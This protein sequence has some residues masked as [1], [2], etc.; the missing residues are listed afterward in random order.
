M[1]L[2]CVMVQFQ[3]ID[4][5]HGRNHLEIVLDDLNPRKV[6]HTH[7]HTH[8]HRHTCARTPHTQTHTGTQRTRQSITYHQLLSI[9]DDML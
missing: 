3:A 2:G 4:G 6:A 1:T 7:T 9:I 8:R 5:A